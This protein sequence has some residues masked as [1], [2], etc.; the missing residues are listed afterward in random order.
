MPDLPNPCS[1]VA[2]LRRLQDWGKKK[3]IADPIYC[4][5]IPLGMLAMK[6]DN[7]NDKHFPKK[8][9]NERLLQDPIHQS[10]A[11]PAVLPYCNDK[12]SVPADGC[13][14]TGTSAL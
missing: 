5:Q 13:E 12:Q 14:P 10:T 1:F 3:S 6:K 7:G 9:S 2:A 11:Q 8:T 4:L